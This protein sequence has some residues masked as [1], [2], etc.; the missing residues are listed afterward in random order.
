MEME[1]RLRRVRPEHIGLPNIILGE[2]AV[3]EFIQH[4]A[5]PENLAEQALKLLREP[6]TRSSM[7]AK[8]T[9]MKDILG[10]PGASRRTAEMVLQLA[11]IQK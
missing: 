10:K 2:R 3:P 9:E 11:G 8:L 4:D 5:T 7:I 1:A 6:D